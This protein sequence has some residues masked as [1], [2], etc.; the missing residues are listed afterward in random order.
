MLAAPVSWGGVGFVSVGGFLFIFFSHF[1]E[2]QL[3]GG[4]GSQ[5]VFVVNICDQSRVGSF[6]SQL[7]NFG[8]IPLNP[9]SSCC[10]G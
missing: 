1:G 6:L 3:P 2:E 10:G 5:Q 4:E 9:I 8:F 7:W